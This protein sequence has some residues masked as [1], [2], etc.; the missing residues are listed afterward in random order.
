MTIGVD[1]APTLGTDEEVI[2]LLCQIAYK[3]DFSGLVTGGSTAYLQL[4]CP[5]KTTLKSRVFPANNV[6]SSNYNVLSNLLKFVDYVKNSFVKK[7]STDITGTITVDPAFSVSLLNVTTDNAGFVWVYAVLNYT[8]SKAVN[9]TILS[10]LPT[11]NLLLMPVLVNLDSGS[12]VVLSSAALTLSG[13]LIVGTTA[14]FSGTYNTATF[15]I[16]YKRAYL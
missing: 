6:G 11:P 16:L 7:G 9:A 10:G 15:T 8:G 2:E 1:V 13:N 5:D 4:N 3:E 14:G 12:A